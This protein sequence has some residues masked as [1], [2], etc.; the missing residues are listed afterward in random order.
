MRILIKDLEQG[1]VRLEG[2]ISPQGLELAPED[3]QILSPVK[4]EVKA[5]KHSLGIRVQG[6]FN[7]HGKVPCAR[8]L[9]SFEFSVSPEFELF[10]QPHDS[11]HPLTGEIE[12]AEKDTNVSFFSGDGIEISNIIREQVLLSLPMK[13][14]CREDCKGLCPNCGCNRNLRPC[15]CESVL[16]DPRLEPLLKIKNRIKVPPSGSK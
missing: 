10:Y 7:A 16:Q 4:V 1:P 11:R 2:E 13:P 14:V 3:I 5:E 8:C 15:H 12:L 6:R 9:E